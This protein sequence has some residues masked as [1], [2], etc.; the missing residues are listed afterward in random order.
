MKK[1]SEGR[2]KPVGSEVKEHRGEGM[3]G[4]SDLGTGKRP[5]ERKEGERSNKHHQERGQC[6]VK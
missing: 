1:G 5:K 4:V 6:G 2:K 3:L